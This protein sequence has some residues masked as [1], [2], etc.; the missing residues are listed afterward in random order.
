MKA[1][2]EAGALA[3]LKENQS[4]VLTAHVSPDGDSLGSMLAL[5]EFLVRQGKQVIVALDDTIPSVYQM[6][7]CW[8]VIRSADEIGSVKADLLVILDASTAD[9][10]GRIAEIVQAPTLNIDH[11]VSNQGFT[12]YLWLDADAAATGE[13]IYRLLEEAKAPITKEMAT[14]LYTAIA[15]DCGFF[16]YANTRPATMRIGADLLSYGVE[17]NVIAEALEQVSLDTMRLTVRA[18][19]TMEFFAEG[20]VAVIT[21]TKDMLE[22]DESTD[23]LINYPRKVEGVE[24]A[25]MLKQKDDRSIKVSMRSRSADVS[26]IAM[27]FGGGGHARAAGCSIDG[28]I[29]EAREKLLAVILPEVGIR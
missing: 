13:I 1:V 25:V 7:P 17:P 4:F 22:H 2:T 29:E 9:R 24:V 14:N 6:L 18:L 5:Y 16:R 11:H 26:Q 23:E 27:Q 28:S 3:L 21:V 15:T 19:Q 12:D 20:K 10:V 8:D